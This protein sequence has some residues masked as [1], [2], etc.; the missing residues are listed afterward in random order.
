MSSWPLS[1]AKGPPKG[2]LR[3][4]YYRLHTTFNMPY[5]INNMP[6]K[7]LYNM[8]YWPLKGTLK[9]ALKG[10]LRDPPSCHGIDISLAL[11]WQ[12]VG[13]LLAPMLAP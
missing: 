9:G 8:P 3:D 10:P 2:P 12:C 13:P 1:D 11:F 6:Y 5:Y 4:P 7:K